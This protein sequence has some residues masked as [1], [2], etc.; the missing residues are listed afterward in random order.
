MNLRPVL[1][2]EDEENDA[3]FLERAFKEV[4][5]VHPLRVVS[6]GQE[7]IDYCAGRGAYVD[8]TKHPLPCVAL[9]DLNM[10]RKSGMQVLQWIRKESSV[11]T[12]PVIILTSSLQDFDIDLAYEQGANA[13]LVKPSQP[14]E[15]VVM[16][17]SIKDF[18][19]TQNQ[20]NAKLA[21]GESK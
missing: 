5:I 7:A 9:L 20:T 13:Y 1:Y 10:P 18:W 11:P 4:G 6:D 8:R 3:Y 21:D 17:R 19:L 16:T 12:L 14:G 15:L 2:A